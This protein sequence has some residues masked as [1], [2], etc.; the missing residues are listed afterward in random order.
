MIYITSNQRVMMSYSQYELL[1]A[2]KQKDIK[3]GRTLTMSVYGLIV[4]DLS[5]LDAW[6]VEHCSKSHPLPF[7]GD[8]E[9]VDEQGKTEYFHQVENILGAHY[10]YRYYLHKESNHVIAKI[11]SLECPK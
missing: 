6:V 11:T 9:T 10:G 7:P 2:L 5:K 3:A 1:E 4:S 8:M